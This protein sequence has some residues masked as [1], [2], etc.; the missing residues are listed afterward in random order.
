MP[1]SICF[2]WDI[3][4]VIFQS[5]QCFIGHTALLAMLGPGPAALAQIPFGEDGQG[6]VAGG[7]YCRIPVGVDGKPSGRD[8]LTVRE[9]DGGT[10]A[11]DR[12]GMA[13]YQAP[14]VTV[15]ST[16]H[17][18]LRRSGPPEEVVVRA[19][20]VVPSMIITLDNA[21]PWSGDRCRF[22][23]HRGPNPVKGGACWLEDEGGGMVP[24]LVGKQA[25]PGAVQITLPRVTRTTRFKLHLEADHPKDEAMAIIEVK[26][27]VTFSGTTFLKKSGTMNFVAGQRYTIKAAH[28]AGGDEGWTWRLKGYGG[29]KRFLEH[30]GSTLTLRAPLVGKAA[31]LTLTATQAGHPGDIGELII[32]L[33]P[34]FRHHLPPAFSPVEPLIAETILPA[35]LGPAFLEPPAPRMTCFAGR[36]WR[37]RPGERLPFDEGEAFDDGHGPKLFDEVTSMAFIQDSAMGGLDAHW[38]VGDY[39]GLLAVSADGKVVTPLPGVQG[40]VAALAS[41]PRGGDPAQPGPHVVFAHR[42]GSHPVLACLNADGSHRHLAGSPEG[43]HDAEGLGEGIWFSDIVGLAMAPDGTVYVADSG[44][45]Q[46]L[47]RVTPEGVVATLA[48]GNPS[49]CQDHGKGLNGT[50]DAAS[51]I[52]LRGMTRDPRNG[53]LYVTDSHTLRKV[54]PEGVVTTV[55]DLMDVLSKQD[56]SVT[57][58]S[59]VAPMGIAIHGDH[60]FYADS[61]LAC[62]RSFNLTTGTLGTFV[63]AP[64]KQQTRLGLVNHFAG[65]A[66]DKDCALFAYPT[67]LAISDSG[68]LLLGDF[69]GLAK[70]EVSPLEALPPA[71]AEGMAG[72]GAPNRAASSP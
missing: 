72:A 71:A 9:P 27:K 63:G 70:V 35:T 22:Q 58:V 18:L 56:R 28:V 24:N 25:G 32:H 6:P 11:V 44:D 13:Y 60:L 10:L 15:P 54:T 3:M 37:P 57:E 61:E 40:S 33:T 14:R 50:G 68:T 41:R 53:D 30:D 2:S 47:R 20:E 62:V 8:L 23:V 52:H 16:F 51:F 34:A 43:P 17:L 55:A 26:P 42:T 49:S 1:M 31:I 4:P 38:L 48:G 5:L 46:V 19:V 66:A 36:L 12:E 7:T 67:S 29:P 65:D 64:H 59:M 39:Q 69:N 21:H 45:H